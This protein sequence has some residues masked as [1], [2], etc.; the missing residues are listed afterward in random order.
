MGGSLY[1]FSSRSLRA[2]SEG[3]GKGDFSSTFKQVKEKKIHESMDPKKIRLREARDSDVHPLTF[4]IIFGMDVTGS[5]REVPKML[6]KDGLPKMISNIIQRGVK[7]PALLFLALGDSAAGDNAPLQVGQFESGDAELDQW[8][9]RTWPEGRGGGNA[10]E[11][12]IWA[13]YFAARHTATDAWEKRKQK[14]LLVTYG[15]EPPL[16]SISINEMREVMGIDIQ[17]SIEAEKILREAQQKWEV[18]HIHFKDHGP[19]SRKWTELLGQKAIEVVDYNE[20]PNVVADLAK[21]YCSYY[22]PE[23]SDIDTG[24]KQTGSPDGTYIPVKDR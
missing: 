2:E 11:S 17:S 21:E 3:Y 5:M 14:G 1:S 24:A 8:L 23:E 10:G 16:M 18:I 6:I 9:T 4:P 22:G 12:Y 15:D 20:I 19:M 7:S 13:W